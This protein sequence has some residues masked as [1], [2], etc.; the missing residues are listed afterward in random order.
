MAGRKAWGCSRWRDGCKLVVPFAVGGKAL[1]PVQ[2]R[3]L[4]TR[5]RTS[6][7]ASWLF[8]GRATK[9]RLRLDLGVEPPALAVEE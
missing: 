4:I 6:R 3:E 9:G 7:K 8:D 5:G 2:L 1:T